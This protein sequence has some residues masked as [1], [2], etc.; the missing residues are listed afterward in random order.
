M[1]HAAMRELLDI[2]LSIQRVLRSAQYVIDYSYHCNIHVDFQT[3]FL[4]HY[5]LPFSCEQL[6]PAKPIHGM[7]HYSESAPQNQPYYNIE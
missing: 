7:Q 3:L 2:E 1:S 6:S 5:R 4:Q